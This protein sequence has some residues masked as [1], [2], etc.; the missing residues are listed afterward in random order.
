MGSGGGAPVTSGLLATTNPN[1][2]TCKVLQGR[3]EAEEEEQKVEKVQDGKQQEE[4]KD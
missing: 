3:K 4:E 2:Q 1:N